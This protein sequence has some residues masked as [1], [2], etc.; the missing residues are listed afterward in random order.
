[1]M[2]HKGKIIFDG[3]PEQIKSTEDPVV[4]RFVLGEASEEE[5]AS[6]RQTV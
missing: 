3:T 2:L 6:L 1:V 5:L 4:R